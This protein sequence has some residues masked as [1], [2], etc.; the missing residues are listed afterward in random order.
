MTQQL[1]EKSLGTDWIENLL[2]LIQLQKLKK[3]SFKY[4][5]FKRFSIY[6]IFKLRF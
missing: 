4:W 1:I 2:S 3:K 6:I 5:L